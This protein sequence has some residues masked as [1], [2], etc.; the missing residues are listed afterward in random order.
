MGFYLA[1]FKCYP[2]KIRYIDK[3]IYNHMKTKRIRLFEDF[4]QQYIK[5]NEVLESV[6]SDWKNR[7]EFDLNSLYEYLVNEEIEDEEE[8]EYTSGEK[9]ALARDFQILSKPQMAAI[10]LRA[11]GI[12]E[13]EDG[14]K[15]LVMIP[16]LDQFGD[17]AE[18]RA[19]EITVPALADALGL[20]SYGTVS[21]TTNKF[22]NL[23]TGEGETPSEAIYPKIVKYFEEFSKQN[24]TALASLAGQ[25]IQDATYTK[26]RDKAADNISKASARAKE[27]KEE[28]VRLGDSVF[29]LIKSLKQNPIF[30][31]PKKAQRAAIMRI[32]RDSGLD[33]SKVDAALQKYLASK[34]ILRYYEK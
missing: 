19:F 1:V 4:Q 29:S 34:D 17:F 23:I 27:R 14:G 10:Y 11:L 20:D 22:V 9:A 6:Y 32:A 26:N 8:I 31:D 21:R 12:A 15:Y 18:D 2:F 13:D 28:L 33:P 25:A 24:P 16:D 3:E 7:L 5:E 30:S